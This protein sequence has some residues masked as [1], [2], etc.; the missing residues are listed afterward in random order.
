MFSWFF[1]F[2]FVYFFKFFK[3]VLTAPEA[4]VEDP[5]TSPVRNLQ[6]KTDLFQ[7]QKVLYHS[8]EEVQPHHCGNSFC[9]PADPPGDERVSQ[10]QKT[11][12]VRAAAKWS[13]GVYR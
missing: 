6:K 7:L 11:E 9:L 1:F 3:L 13:S 12:S 2:L 5:V 8:S 10:S 4:P